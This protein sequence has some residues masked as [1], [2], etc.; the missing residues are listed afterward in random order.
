M[1][2]VKIT[3]EILNKKIE[4]K[5]SRFDM[6]INFYCCVYKDGNYYLVGY[7]YNPEWDLYYPFYDDV[8]KTPVLKQSTANTYGELLKETDET[9]LIDIEEKLNYAKQRFFELI[10][11]RC[12]VEKSD[13]DVLYELKYSKTANLYTIYKLFN[14]IV[15]DVQDI[16][17]MLNPTNLTDCKLF[18]LENLKNEK[19]VENASWF[20]N[21]A[22]DELKQKAISIY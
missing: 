9:I 22:I 8:N 20:V 6:A 10:G 15:T 4:N 19:I 16:Q 3:D 18:D 11:T 2:N 5:P 21:E 1:N 12:N 7:Y 17:K 13:I 14:F